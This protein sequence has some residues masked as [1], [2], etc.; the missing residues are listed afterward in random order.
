MLITGTVHPPGGASAVIAATVPV[1]T[2][3]GWFFVGLVMYGCTLMLAVA[4]VLN[5]IQRQFPLYWWTPLDLRKAKAKDVETWP[6][7]KGALEQRRKNEDDDD[8]TVEGSEDGRTEIGEKQG[9]ISIS[10]CGVLVPKDL[11]L[12]QEETRLLESLRDRLRKRRQG[13]G[14]ESERSLEM[15]QSRGAA[16]DGSESTLG[17]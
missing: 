9:E 8:E 7:A 17:P 11:S 6:D 14:G 16:S 4:L 3:M 10:A 2:E 1:F 5:N 13:D 15:V 12:N